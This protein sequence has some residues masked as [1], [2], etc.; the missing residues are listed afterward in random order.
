MLTAEQIEN[1]RQMLPLL[2]GSPD[3]DHAHAARKAA[4]DA[5]AAYERVKALLERCKKDSLGLRPGAPY[6]SIDELRRALE[7]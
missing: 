2:Y 1:A 6:I 4:L 3:E 7:G 5:L